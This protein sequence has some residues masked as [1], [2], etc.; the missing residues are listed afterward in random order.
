[1]DT[2]DTVYIYDV[3]KQKKQ[4]LNDNHATTKNSKMRKRPS[5]KQHNAVYTQT[6][7]SVISVPYETKHPITFHYSPKMTHRG[8]NVY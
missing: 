2:A 1:M 3:R 5:H 8:R 4:R 6:M 7:N